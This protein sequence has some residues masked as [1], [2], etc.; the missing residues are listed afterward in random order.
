MLI[1][2]KPPEDSS[3]D[4]YNPAT[5]EDLNKQTDLWRLFSNGCDALKT[6]M[7]TD[8]GWVKILPDRPTTRQGLR[9]LI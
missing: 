5:N 8:L 1:M 6:D 4:C 7:Q 3:G 9:T 2:K